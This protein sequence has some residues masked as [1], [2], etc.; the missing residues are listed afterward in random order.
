MMQDHFA[1]VRRWVTPSDDQ[2]PPA[3]EQGADIYTA[4]VRLQHLQPLQ[5]AYA[6]VLERIG[7]TR[8]DALAMAFRAAHP[9]SDAHP[10]RWAQ[11]F[12]IHYAEDASLELPLRELIDFVGVRLACSLAPEGP[13][14]GELRAYEQDPRAG[15]LLRPV[16]LYIVR[17]L[18]GRVRVM[19]VDGPMTAALGLLLGETTLD[20]LHS[21]GLTDEALAAAR[22]RLI[23][24]GVPGL[25]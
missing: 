14:R 23:A 4:F 21:V 19:E 3:R 22:V 20:V 7:A 10:G 18:D 25:D 2:R 5:Q 13:A 16:A 6:E 9:P 8:F 15:H 17:A 1:R 12:A 24:A 11:G